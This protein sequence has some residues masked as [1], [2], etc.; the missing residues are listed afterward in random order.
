MRTRKRNQHNASN[1]HAYSNVEIACVFRAVCNLKP[2]TG[3]RGVGDGDG[4]GFQCDGGATF[5]SDMEV[6]STDS[7]NETS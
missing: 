3:A 4:N 2:T 6:Q 1:L 7:P 5:H